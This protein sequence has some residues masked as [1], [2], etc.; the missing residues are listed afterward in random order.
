MEAGEKKALPVAL[1]RGY[2]DGPRSWNLIKAMSFVKRF[3]ISSS[4][5]GQATEKI[6][7]RRFALSTAVAQAPSEFEVVFLHEQVRYRYGFSVDEEQVHREWLY[8]AAPDQSAEEELFQRDLGGIQ[9][10]DGFA[11]G[12]GLERRTRKNALFL[13]LVAQLNGEL[14]GKILQWFDSFKGSPVWR[15][16]DPC[17]RARR[18]WPGR[19]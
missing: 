18:S 1:D 6:Q 10:R 4:K 11:E 7:V 19:G 5:E 17:T 16:E 2:L 14:A 12:R 3:A 15:I 13:S 8:R 9:V